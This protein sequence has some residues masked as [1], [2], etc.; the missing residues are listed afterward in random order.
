MN[1][2]KILAT[3]SYCYKEM[4][5][6]NRVIGIMVHSTG[7]NNP[8]L[9]RYVSPDN[10]LIG[11]PSSNNW[12]QYYINGS[13]KKTMVH[14]FI[15]KLADGSIATVQ[16]Q[17]WNKKCYH[18]GTGTSGKSGN[19]NYIS[20]EICEDNLQNKEYFNA[21]YKEA[22]ELCA[23]LCNEFGFNPLKNITCHKEAY[24]LGFASGHEDILH[25]F[26]LYGKTMDDFRNDVKKEMEDENM[27]QDKFNEL[28]AN[29]QETFDK[30]MDKY[31]ENKKDEP[32]SNW[33]KDVQDKALVS[34]FISGDDK[35]RPMWQSFI[36]REQFAILMNKAGILDEY[37]NKMK[38]KTE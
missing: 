35:G 12:N 37:D 19:T 21:V 24:D 27:T 25:W 5:N 17:E 1:L 28:M 2:M 32:G 14:A 3:N 33:C 22:V 18:C 34:G 4:P 38:S 30:M 11:K 15:G 13:V 23:Y 26:K 29:S 7:C 8:N 16:V 20:F 31:L 36:T 10:G 9:R 6:M